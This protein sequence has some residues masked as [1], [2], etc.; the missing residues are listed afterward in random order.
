MNT[1]KHFKR[2]LQFIL[3]SSYSEIT[4]LDIAL[5]N[6]GFFLLLSLYLDNFSV[7]LQDGAVIN[8]SP[9]CYMNDPKKAWGEE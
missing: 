5:L 2:M 3:D 6:L 9:R 7:W 8:S 1:I 4:L